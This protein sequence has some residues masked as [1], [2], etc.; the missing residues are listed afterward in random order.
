MINSFFPPLIEKNNKRYASLFDR[1]AYLI[2]LGV[3]FIM[4]LKIVY[5]RALKKNFDCRTKYADARFS[6]KITSFISL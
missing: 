3:G 5:S 4:Y 6:S 2:L 1:E